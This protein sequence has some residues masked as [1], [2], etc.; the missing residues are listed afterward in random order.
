MTLRLI[1]LRSRE[2]WVSRDVDV[3]MKRLRGVKPGRAYTR[4]E[5]NAR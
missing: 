5:M 4:D 1:F 2:R 3:L